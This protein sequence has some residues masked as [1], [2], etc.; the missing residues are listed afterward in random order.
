MLYAMLFAK[1]PFDSVKDVSSPEIP[2]TLAQLKRY[3]RALFV[4]Q[5]L[6]VCVSACRFTK[7]GRLM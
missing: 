6:C 4:S 5:C 3:A 1:Y 7:K 2:A